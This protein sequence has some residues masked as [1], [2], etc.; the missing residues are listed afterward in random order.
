MY[1]SNSA[2]WAPS[3]R[4]KRQGRTAHLFVVTQISATTLAVD[5]NHPLAGQTVSFEVMVQNIRDAT[6]AEVR[7]GDPSAT[8]HGLQ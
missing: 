7:N 4:R 6:P 3:W 1:P 8:G 2:T 5:A